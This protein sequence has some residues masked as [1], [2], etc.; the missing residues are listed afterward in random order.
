MCLPAEGCVHLAALGFDSVTCVC[1]RGPL[2]ECQS[3]PP[4]I[5]RRQARSCKLF[6]HAAGASDEVKAK[7]R[8][9]AALRALRAAENATARAGKK[10]KITGGCAAALEAALGD[11]ANRTRE[12]LGSL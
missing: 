4:L 7:K 5:E 1:E 2:P 12:L 3:V 8:L 6:A 10:G 9:R 11:A